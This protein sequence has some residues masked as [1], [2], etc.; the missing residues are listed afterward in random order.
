MVAAAAGWRRP[1]KKTLPEKQASQSV[2]V[3]VIRQA[4]ALLFGGSFAALLS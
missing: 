1:V 2:G 3:A 4:A